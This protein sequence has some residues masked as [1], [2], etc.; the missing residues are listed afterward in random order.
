M[1][2]ETFYQDPYAGLMDQ[3][4]LHERLEHLY[5]CL[6]EQFSGIERFS[7]ALY[8]E[9]R[10]TLSTFATFGET[11]KA[12]EGYQ[13]KLWEVQS[14]Q[15]LVATGN[16][17]VVHDMRQL[18]TDISSEHTDTLLAQ[19]FRSSVTM[20]LFDAGKLRGVMFLNSRK[21]EY[22]TEPM[23]VYCTL[24]AHLAGT[25]FLKS[26]EPLLAESA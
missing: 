14:L 12:L 20:P 13:V 22:F 21:S 24:W 8:N 25:L 1:S 10:D 26:E 5:H 18:R 7:I 3:G 6:R 19:G 4:S 11:G 15:D 2:H 16:I 9:D 23:V 17:R